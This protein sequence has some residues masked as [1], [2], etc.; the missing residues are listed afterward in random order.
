MAIEVS[1]FGCL[2][3]GR[4]VKKIVIKNVAGTAVSVLTYG[5]TVQA[6]QYRDKDVVLGYDSIEGYLNNAGYLGATVGRVAN[7]TAGGRFTLNGQEIVVDCNE[8]ERGNHLHGGDEGFS[9]KLWDYTILR[10]GLD[11]SVR[12]DLVSEDGEGGYPG[13]L[14]VS[15][16]FSLNTDN[17]LELAYA[18]Q[19][20][21]DTVVNL[22]NHTY[23]NLNGYQGDTVLNHQIKLAAACY[24]PVNELLI[25]TGEIAPVEG[26][27]LDLRHPTNVGQAV[28]A[29]DG[30]DHNFVLADAKREV[31][32]VAWVYSP[33][34]GMRVTCSTDMPGIQVYTGNFLTGATGKEGCPHPKHQ[35]LCLETQYFPNSVNTPTFPSIV[36]KAGEEYSS[37]TRYR[38]EKK[39]IEG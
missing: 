21:K 11:P 29:V 13:R 32:D 25:P 22:T 15:V 5:A 33:V 7:R 30:I 2:R 9:K 3:D 37:I 18:A 1:N 28:A 6:I 36:L 4:I 26:T 19:S 17:V 24:T 20:D 10:E 34:T 12:F 35:G 38:F 23:F 39:P 8:E 31:T 16:T 27:P 14:E